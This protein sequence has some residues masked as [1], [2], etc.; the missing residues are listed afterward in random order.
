MK[1]GIKK[2][3]LLD[4]IKGWFKTPYERAIL[5]SY[6]R[7]SFYNRDLATNETIYA[8]VSMLSKAIASAPVNVYK[9][10]NK[11][12]PSEHKLAE[13]FKFGPNS[14]QT[15]F[16]FMQLM[17]T[18]R[19]IKGAAYAIIEYSPRGELQQLWVLN[20]DCV[21]PVM[22][23]ETRELYYKI[24]CEGV[25]NYVHNNY[26]IDVHGLTTDGYTPISPLDVLRNTIDYDREVKEFS[27]N[28]M[29]N[30]LKANLVVTLSTKLDE[31]SLSVYND[32]MKNFKDS[33]I[34]YVDQGKSITELKNS[35]FIDPNIAAVEKITIERVERVFSL[36][37]KLSR[38][39]ESKTSEEDL[40]YLKDTIL[41]LVRMYEQEFSRKLLSYSEKY[42]GYEVKI[43]ING[44]LRA[45][46]K[47]RA[48]FYQYMI[49]NGI[50]CPNDIA[51]LEDIPPHE[52]GNQYYVSRDLC[53][54][55]QIRDLISSGSN[56]S[57]ETPTQTKKES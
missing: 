46:A 37:G 16:N 19:N 15:M 7:F 42:K 41:P 23:T 28:Q 43:N 38:T 9:N 18:L 24:D 32:M 30:G 44:F 10:Y 11:L 57:T 45:S 3:K 31:K 29:Q 47:D 4:K 12:N 35:S 20:N 36:Y 2:L 56:T 49:R 25:Q 33:G 40:L 21:E 27:L 39:D 53:P 51:V 6:R 50:Y 22:E 55:D 1:G 17:E 48:V 13:M 34:I 5:G 14:F 26:I 54:I 8:A 52:G